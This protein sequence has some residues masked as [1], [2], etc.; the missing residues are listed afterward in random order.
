VAVL[1]L[2]ADGASDV[3]VTSPN[4][5]KVNVAAPKPKIPNKSQR[6]IGIMATKLI[7]NSPA[8]TN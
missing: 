7:G 6:G 2:S 5:P 8:L 1:A 3:E 4:A